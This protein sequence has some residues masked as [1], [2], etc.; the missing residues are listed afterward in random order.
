[1][2]Y[3]ISKAT[4]NWVRSS[5]GILIPDGYR[6]QSSHEVTRSLLQLK[7]DANKITELAGKAG[8]SIPEAS[9]FSKLVSSAIKASDDFLIGEKVSNEAYL[10]VAQFSRVCDALLALDGTDDFSQLIRKLC[11]GPLNLLSRVQSQPKNFLWEGELLGILRMCNLDAVMREPPD[12]VVTCLGE[13]I[14]VACKKLYS[15]K[16]VE[17]V[18]SNGVR[19]LSA[20]FDHGMVAFN[21]DDLVAE[22]FVLHEVSET[23]AEE[24]IKLLNRRFIGNHSRHFY[25][26]LNSERV[27]AAVVSTSVIVNIGDDPQSLRNIRQTMVWTLPGNGC[28]INPVMRRFLGVLG[29]N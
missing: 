8:I 13:E 19:Q 10:S 25:K 23:N 29:N 28:G 2:A 20:S 15:E 12:I 17:K 16:N 24:R 7:S 3:G 18:F 27:S 22:N 21:L 4:R 9:D 6:V 11:S 14:G 5:G 1:M 26:Y